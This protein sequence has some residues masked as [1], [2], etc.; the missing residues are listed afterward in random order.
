MRLSI[1]VLCLTGFWSYAPAQ[2]TDGGA[3]QLLTTSLAATAKAMHA[4]IRRNIIEA[5]EAMPAE[6]YDFKPTPQIR[7]FAQ[8]LGHVT[9]VNYF[10][11]SEAKGAP[12]PSKTSASALTAKDAAVKALKDSFAYCDDVYA[13]LTDANFNDHVTVA[14]FGN[15]PTPTT[16]GQVLMFN[17]T[18]NTEH[19]GNAVI[20]LRLKGITPPSTARVQRNG[21]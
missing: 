8:L 3:D 4:S 12:Y 2:T 15:K 14:G 17:T 5:A 16:R 13:E 18:H 20:Y 7:T 10:F 1:L 11:C 21:K 19:Y 9:D 6:S